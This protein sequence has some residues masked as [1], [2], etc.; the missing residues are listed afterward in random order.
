MRASSTPPSSL[1]T[2]DRLAFPRPDLPRH[3]L[4]DAVLAV[5]SAHPA[6]VSQAIHTEDEMLLFALDARAGDFD[7]AVADYVYSGARIVASLRQIMDWRFGG[8]ERV[9]RYLDFASGW[10]RVTRFLLG[11]LPAERLWISEIVAPAVA[12]QHDR[13]G[14]HGILS[15]TDPA[16]FACDERFD[17]IVVTSLFTHLPAATFTGWL[18]RLTALLRPGGLL[19]FSAHDT[20]LLPRDWTP[21]ADGLLFLPMSESLVLDTASYG[22]TWVTPDYVARAVD[23][24]AAELGEPLSLGRLARGYCNLHDLYLV[25]REA[26]TDFRTLR[27]ERDAE[28]FLDSATLD[29]SRQ[30]RLSG[31]CT[32]PEAPAGT[33]ASRIVRVEL[34]VDGQLLS[35]DEAFQPRPDVAAALGRPE[36]EASGW[37]V[38]GPLSR[39]ASPTT[40]SLLVRAV[41]ASGRGTMLY[42]GTVAM[43]L[44]QN[45]RTVIDAHV[46]RARGLVAEAATLAAARDEARAEAHHLAAQIDRLHRELA[47]AQAIA[48]AHGATIG[49][50]RTTIAELER[51]LAEVRASRFWRARELWHRLKGRPRTTG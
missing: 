50:Q 11:E 2:A 34:Y 7:L 32:Y 23:R 47:A 51:Q 48:T 17:A 29:E 28:G 21:P 40:T 36:V 12:F 3:P 13:L 18:S 1:P 5:E 8:F 16:A 46:S 44:L 39:L 9:G 14:V 25:T 42:A 26:G 31:W 45:A 35:T 38:G 49:T 30:L 19:V 6:A 10:G 20:S 4:V 37:V 43:A 24:V 33:A 15:V 22:S 41:T 27:Y